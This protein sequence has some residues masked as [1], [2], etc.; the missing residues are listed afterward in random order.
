[1]KFAWHLVASPAAICAGTHGVAAAEQYTQHQLAQQSNGQAKAPVPAAAAF[2]RSPDAFE[3]APFM[4]AEL[5]LLVCLVL[6][7]VLMPPPACAEPI[8]VVVVPPAMMGPILEPPAHRC[9]ARHQTLAPAQVPVHPPLQAHV[10]QSSQL[11]ACKSGLHARVN[12]EATLRPG[13]VP[14]AHL[15]GHVGPILPCMEKTRAEKC[16]LVVLGM[17]LL[18]LLA[19]VPPLRL[20]PP[21]VLLS[22]LISLSCPALLMLS[23][24]ATCEESAVEVGVLQVH[25]A[26]PSASHNGS[27][28]SSH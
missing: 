13:C 14:L 22:A 19:A 18:P 1:M 17:V 26:T 25:R 3:P 15:C 4:A 27:C 9:A 24:E 28:S 7:A 23:V 12:R 16:A 2:L 11:H 21:T 8:E 6:D 5:V 20:V 10:E